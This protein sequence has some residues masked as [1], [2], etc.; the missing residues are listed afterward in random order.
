MTVINTA[1]SQFAF[2]RVVFE[3]LKDFE[4][5][6]RSFAPDTF[7]AETR[8]CAAEKLAEIRESYEE[9]GGSKAYWDALE[10]EVLDNVT[11]QYIAHARPYTEL[12][13]ANFNVW[14][15]GDLVSRFVFALGGL[16]LGGV[17]IA[18]PFIPIFEDAF[19]F[20]LCF[21]GFIYPDLKRYIF[22]RRHARE[23]NRLV[24]EST[25]YQKSQSYEFVSTARLNEAL[26]LEPHESDEERRARS[27]GAA[28]KQAQ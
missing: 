10:Q 23:L 27:A 4:H 13:A 25:E 1:G 2:G 17:I 19:A 26:S 3:V 21:G 6:R 11:T 14:R 20:A 24:S 8:T 15:G 22:E 16:T 28:E 7:D 5:R 12:E 9:L 18:L